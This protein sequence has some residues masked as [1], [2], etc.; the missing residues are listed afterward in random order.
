LRVRVEAG[1]E[2]NRLR[3]R[4]DAFDDAVEDL[5]VHIEP[6]ARGA[7]L[8]RV[9]EDRAGRT[10]DDRVDIGIGQNDHGR[11]AAELERDALERV[12]GRLI[13][14]LADLRGARERDLVDARMRDERGTHVLAITRK[15]VDDTGR[16]T[17]FDDELAEAQRRER[18][19]IG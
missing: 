10:A 5:A 11:L 4:T 6:R 16:E 1:A 17:G 7:D 15:N 14:E 3:G 12:G 19:Q 13:D 2:A 8:A 18:R 9:E